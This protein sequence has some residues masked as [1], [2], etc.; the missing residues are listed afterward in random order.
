[1]QTLLSSPY[2]AVLFDM[3]NTLFDFY[4]CM[5]AGCEAAVSVLSC[6]T[7]EELYS[8]YF[9]GRHSIEDHMNLQDFMNAHECFSVPLYFKT[10]AAFDAAKLNALVPYA[11]IREV[12]SVLKENKYLLGLI[13][14]AYTYAADERLKK[15]G[16]A[17][18]F[19]ARVGYDTTG[20]KK[21]HHAPF[22]CALDLLNCTPDEA[23]YVGD[24]VRRDIEPATAVGMTAI[25]ARYGDVH[26]NFYQPKLAVDSPKE[27]LKVLKIE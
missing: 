8:Y 7:P 22:E 3:D 15:T 12:L 27:I 16:L 21:P 19:D 10:V 17:D 11:G 9:R 1:M 6:G 4:S 13:T 20:Y 23:V 2:K 25:H 26:E 18:F 5:R 14:D 24:S